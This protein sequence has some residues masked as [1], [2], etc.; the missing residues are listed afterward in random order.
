MSNLVEI[1]V[2]LLKVSDFNV[3]KTNIVHKAFDENIKSLG[4]IQP[5]TV[6]RVNGKFEVVIGQSRFNAGKK[7][8]AETLPCEVRQMTDT[9]AIVASLSENIARHNLA[10]LDKA[11]AIAQLLGQNELLK[12]Y[13]T[14]RAGHGETT[15]T[16]RELAKRL[17]V[18]DTTV[19]RW[20]EP[21]RLQPET[22]EL[23][24]AGAVAKKVAEKIRKKAKTPE[25]EVEL[26]N[27]FAK[28]DVGL[29]PGE[30]GALPER[31]GVA[32]LN[33]D[34][35]KEELIEELGA[36]RDPSRVEKEPKEDSDEEDD[37]GPEID[38]VVID[39]HKVTDPNLIKR[40][41]A[42]GIRLADYAE[43]MLKCWLD[44]QG[45]L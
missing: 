28:V 43:E 33:K 11:I 35:S 5:L 30:K 12:D 16:E 38:H 26:A 37:W 2:S 6:R 39:G 14:P 9:E 40:L 24:E 41:N 23:V 25:E 18:T 10:P 42:Y 19:D 13:A 21:L 22:R 34:L 4:V 8:G 17:G 20:L 7:A 36:I 44:A 15:Y 32:L 1:P 45:L 27:E 3:R 31:E 29:K